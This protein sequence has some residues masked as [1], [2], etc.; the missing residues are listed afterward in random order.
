[1]FRVLPPSNRRTRGYTLIELAV[2]LVVAGIVT[3]GFSYFARVAISQQNRLQDAE[4]VDGFLAEVT[5][6]AVRNNRLPCA[7]SA[8]DAEGLDGL[9]DCAL[10]GTGLPYQTL[11]LDAVSAGGIIYHPNSDLTFA[12]L[13]DIEGAF[14]PAAPASDPFL[15]PSWKVEAIDPDRYCNALRVSIQS[16]AEIGEPAIVDA[17]ADC[18]AGNVLANPAFVLVSPGARDADGADDNSLYDGD[19]SDADNCY[20]SPTRAVNNAYDDAVMVLSKATLAGLVC[21]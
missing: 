2:Y 12:D 3:A 7:D 6:F 15:K 11:L 19:N 16:A 9:E 17:G 21:P 18:T 8:A 14:V 4:G 5:D 1:M 20:E 13:D 10:D